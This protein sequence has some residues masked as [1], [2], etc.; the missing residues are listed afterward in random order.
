M[1]DLISREELIKEACGKCDGACD[2]CCEENC[3]QCKRPNMRCDFRKD[4]DDAPTVDA[5]PV[6]HGRWIN[7]TENRKMDELCIYTTERVDCS[8]CDHI[9]WHT[10]ALTY[11][12]CPHCG[13]KMDGGNEE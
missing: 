7:K 8:V 1:N 10:S 9:F 2:C 3:I 5:V 13:A 11:S 12:F 4:L 6:V